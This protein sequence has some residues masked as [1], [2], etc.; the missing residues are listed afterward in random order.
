MTISNNSLPRYH[1]HIWMQLTALLFNR[2]I[3][4]LMA[5]N[6]LWY[7]CSARSN[8]LD[9]ICTC[10]SVTDIPVRSLPLLQF[11]KRR[12]EN[13][14]RYQ[15]Q[16][17]SAAASQQLD[18]NKQTLDK[19]RPRLFLAFALLLTISLPPS[20]AS[21]DGESSLSDVRSR[22]GGVRHRSKRLVVPG[23]L[24]VVQCM[25]SFVQIFPVRFYID[26]HKLYDRFKGIVAEIAHSCRVVHMMIYRQ[27]TAPLR[28]HNYESTFRRR[29]IHVRRMAGDREAAA[30]ENFSPRPAAAKQKRV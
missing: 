23:C 12:P 10:S 16:A 29:R 28:I 8:S 22:N 19:M 21:S 6:A 30:T 13:K 27:N 2:H 5:S 26:L 15:F 25:G 17:G 20:S 1:R 3:Y 24:T 7:S 9:R 18:N 4:L 11:V 14:A